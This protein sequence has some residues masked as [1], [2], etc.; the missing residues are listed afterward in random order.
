[1]V[2]A[3]P[4]AGQSAYSYA[5]RSFGRP[6]GF[7]VGWALLLDYIFLPM[8]HDLVIGLYMQDYFPSNA[9]GACG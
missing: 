4:I 1:M 7:M 3:Q 5:S 8:I 9:A 6:I 2:I